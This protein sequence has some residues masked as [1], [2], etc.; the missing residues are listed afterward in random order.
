MC[1]AFFSFYLTGN[2]FEYHDLN[3]FIFLLVITVQFEMEEQGT[4]EN[5]SSYSA[6]LV[7][8]PVLLS[9][10]IAQVEHFQVILRWHLWNFECLSVSS[11]KYELMLLIDTNFNTG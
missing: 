8:F 1:F 7:Q 10:F 4:Q 2:N 3:Q 6:A 11:Q 9:A 5:K